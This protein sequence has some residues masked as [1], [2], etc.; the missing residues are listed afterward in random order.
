MFN[1]ILNHNEIELLTVTKLIIREFKS[2]LTQVTF[3]WFSEFLRNSAYFAYKSEKQNDSMR[4]LLI[5]D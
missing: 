3:C 5:I 1:Y 2:I 4:H